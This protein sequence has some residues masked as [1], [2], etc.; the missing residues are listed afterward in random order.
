MACLYI[1]GLFGGLGVLVLPNLSRLATEEENYFLYEAG[2]I[3]HVAACLPD[4]VGRIL[5]LCSIASEIRRSAN[6]R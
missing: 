5:L 2:P 6:R 3:Y 4:E 1:F